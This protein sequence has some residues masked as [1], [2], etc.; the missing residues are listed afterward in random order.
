MPKRYSQE[1]KRTVQTRMSEQ[2]RNEFE[3]LKRLRLL[4]R[5]QQ[6]EIGF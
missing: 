3:A 6:A 4:V 5:E 2:P 1:I